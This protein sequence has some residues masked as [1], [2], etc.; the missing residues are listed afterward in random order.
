M[1]RHSGYVLAAAAALLGGCGGAKPAEPAVT[2]TTA[3]TATTQ[4]RPPTVTADD[5]SLTITTKTAPPVTIATTTPAPATPSDDCEALGM[6]RQKLREGPCSH[7][8]IAV[9]VANRGTLVRLRE[10]SVRL[11]GFGIRPAEAGRVDA[12]LSL[13]V[14]NHLSRRVAFD[15]RGD[16]ARLD[17]GSRSYA[18]DRAV[19][20]TPSMSFAWKNAGIDP[21]R[22]QT[23]TIA[24]RIPRSQIA[25]LSRSASLVVAQFSDAGATTPRRRVA[26]LRTYH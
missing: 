4:V 6:T 24:F 12:L 1:R 11:N 13:T 14:G 22:A 17:I 9:Y 15:A 26:I 25:R 20:D 21:G 5:N 7:G 19:E 8:G 18:E 10:M 2:A 3:T 23:G 16:Q